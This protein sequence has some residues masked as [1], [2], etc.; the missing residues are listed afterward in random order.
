M[1]K[2]ESIS[3]KIRTETK[4]STLTG[5]IQYSAWNIRAIKQEKNIKDI[6]IEN[7]EV[8]LSLFVDGMILYLKY[9]KLHQKTLWSGKKKKKKKKK[10]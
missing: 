7:E 2:T 9:P 8:K 4:V 10:N 3:F 6:E 1:G 5:L